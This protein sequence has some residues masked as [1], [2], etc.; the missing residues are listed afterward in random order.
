[1]AYRIEKDFLGEKQVPA[2]A[3]YGVQTVRGLENFHITG[4]PMS[5]EPYFVKAF[6]YVRKAATSSISRAAACMRP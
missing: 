1:M 5:R 6:G 2:D 4:M 3:Y